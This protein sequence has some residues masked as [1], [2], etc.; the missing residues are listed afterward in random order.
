[1]LVLLVGCGHPLRGDWAGEIGLDA[2]GVLDFSLHVES[3]TP[4]AEGTGA[5]F[6]DGFSVA[7]GKVGQ[8]P[9]GGD[10]LWIVVAD[11][12]PDLEWRLDLTGQLDS[13]TWFGEASFGWSAEPD[14]AG[15][16]F[17]C[18]GTG[19][20]LAER[21]GSASPSTSRR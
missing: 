5:L 12:D 19:E 10:S 14:Y 13:K 2:G 18:T 9:S 4:Y 15:E 3:V 6:C 11:D 21:E 8:I 17:G 1:M 20:F 16:P 7:T